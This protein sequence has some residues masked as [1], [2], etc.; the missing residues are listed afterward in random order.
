MLKNRFDLPVLG[1][2]LDAPA[3]A[4]LMPLADGELVQT[5]EADMGMTYAELSTMGRARKID[6]AG[7]YSMFVSL[8]SAW[9]D[10]HPQ[11]VSYF[12]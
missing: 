5:D 1:D 9:R 3:T 12:R 10:V 8:S 11:Q 7:P 4:E 6:R 2:I